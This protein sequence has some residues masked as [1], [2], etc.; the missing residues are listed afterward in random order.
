M[1]ILN[2]LNIKGS[3]IQAIQHHIELFH[4][5][6][7]VYLFGSILSQKEEPN[8]IDLLLIYETLTSEILND[9][10][11]IKDT[12]AQLYG[13]QF[14]L[15]VISENEEDESKLIGRLNSRYIRLK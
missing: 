12:F 15:T 14:D 7:G 2:D 3:V 10:N 11:E 6:E 1:D 5:F 9:L 4:S 13:I 8:D